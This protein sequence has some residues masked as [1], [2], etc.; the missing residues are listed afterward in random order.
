[1]DSNV[2]ESKVYSKF[3]WFLFVIVIPTLFTITL[4]LVLLTI[5]GVNVFEYAKVIGQNTPI[6]SK[7]VPKEADPVV[8]K[9]ENLEHQISSLEGKI[10]EKDEKIAD[11][12]KKLEGQRIEIS[13]LQEEI[14]SLEEQ[15]LLKEEEQKKHTKT[16]A[17]ISKLYETMSPKN[18]AVIIPKLDNEEA[19]SILSALKTETVS[20]ILEK[21]DPEDAAKYTQ[22]LTE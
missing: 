5:A 11:L 15:L 9:K 4:A 7:Y 10:Q 8:E 2:S 12:E 13:Y 1:M 6:I 14:F 19:I 17:E 20:K 18:A 3:Q 21:M 22:L 16:I